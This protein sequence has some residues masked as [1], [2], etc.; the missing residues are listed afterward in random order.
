MLA[1]LVDRIVPPLQALAL[2]EHWGRP[3]HH[4]FPG[5]HFVWLGRRQV[6]ERICAHLRSSLAD[7]GRA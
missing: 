6:R 5:S 1:G 7:T 4:W 3:A 2:W